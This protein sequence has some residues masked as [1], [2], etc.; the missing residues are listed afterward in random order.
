MGSIWL[1]KVSEVRGG[2]CRYFED[3]LSNF[4]AS[5]P[6]LYRVTLPCISLAQAQSLSS[7]FL[8]KVDVVVVDIDGSKTL[9]PDGLKFLFL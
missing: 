9:R 5:R 8:Q 7:R 4:V 2:I 3:R 1:D 6:T